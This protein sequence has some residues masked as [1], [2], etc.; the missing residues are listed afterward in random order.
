VEDIVRY[1]ALVILLAVMVAVGVNRREKST[2]VAEC[3]LVGRDVGRWLSAL[4][5]GTLRGCGLPFVGCMGEVSHSFG[6][7]GPRIARGHALVGVLP[8]PPRRAAVVAFAFR[9]C[10][11]PATMQ[12]AA[13][14][15]L[16]GTN[17]E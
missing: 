16:H 11:E 8:T 5:G 3:L 13:E 12:P 4:A 17:D 2:T 9:G 7:P 10:E 6:L 15:V 14:V 1:E